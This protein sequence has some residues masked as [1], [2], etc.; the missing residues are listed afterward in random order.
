MKTPRFLSEFCGL[1]KVIGEDFFKGKAF[2]IKVVLSLVPCVLLATKF[3]SNLPQ[4]L[5]Q[6]ELSHQEFS[7]GDG[8]IE[9]RDEFLGNLR[10]RIQSD[11]ISHISVPFPT[12]VGSASQRKQEQAGFIE[13]MGKAR[14]LVKARVTNVGTLSSSV[15]T[16]SAKLMESIGG[17]MY[18]IGFASLPQE[19]AA[20]PQGQITPL[21]NPAGQT[22]EFG[23]SSDGLMDFQIVELVGRALRDRYPKESSGDRF[24]ILTSYLRLLALDDLLRQDRLVSIADP[25]NQARVF[26]VIQVYDI[27]GRG[28]AAEC[29]IID[30]G[31]WK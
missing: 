25:E 2:W 24:K 22:I 4:L 17:H 3:R 20:L 19:D 11:L 23:I 26:L 5:V 18:P 15:S 27:Y 10:I 29:S 6:A 9:D 16:V 13:K 21:G 8:P 14:F 12:A 1:L 30:S 28:G 31:A 7:A